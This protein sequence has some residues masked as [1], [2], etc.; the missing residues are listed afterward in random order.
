MHS[1]ACRQPS[2]Q[3]VTFK[4]S[5]SPCCCTVHRVTRIFCGKLLCRT[6]NCAPTE[7]APDGVKLPATCTPHTSLT[8]IDE[9]G[10]G[11]GGGGG[12][13]EVGHY[14]HE[15]SA[16][17]ATSQSDSQHTSWKHKKKNKKLRGTPRLSSDMQ[18]VCMSHESKVAFKDF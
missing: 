17:L 4:F 10:G 13:E 12:G 1:H 15:S 6:Y 8:W 2:K 11:G 3:P 18:V 16:L 9:A 7:F 5:S 14:S